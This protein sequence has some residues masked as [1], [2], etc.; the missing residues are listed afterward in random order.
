MFSCLLQAEERNF[1]RTWG[2]PFRPSLYIRC[3]LWFHCQKKSKPPCS[4]RNLTTTSV[5]V[6]STLR[7]LSVAGLQ[8]MLSRQ[9]GECLGIFETSTAAYCLFNP[10]LLLDRFVISFELSNKPKMAVITTA[11]IVRQC[12]H[13]LLP[14]GAAPQS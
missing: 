6:H 5:V 13:R 8:K 1:F 11:S 10:R 12:I 3:I 7:F 9:C 14:P 4:Q 2:P